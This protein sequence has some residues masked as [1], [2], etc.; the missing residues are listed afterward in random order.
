MSF[1]KQ[2]AQKFSVHYVTGSVRSEV[3]SLRCPTTLGMKKIHISGVI[4]VE[5]IQFQDKY[6]LAQLFGK[7]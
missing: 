7:V 4:S 1:V 6:I 2:Q 3:R 5:K